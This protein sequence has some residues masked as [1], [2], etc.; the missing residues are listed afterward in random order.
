MNNKKENNKI[1]NIIKINLI[2]GIKVISIVILLFITNSLNIKNMVNAESIN[3]ADV[4][5]IGDC[6]SLLTYQGI[7]VKTNY[8]QYI[9]DGVAYPAYCMDKTKVGVG[10]TPY[11]VSIQSAIQDVGL[12]RRV[13]NGYPYKTIQELGVANKEE[14]FTATKQAIYCYIHGNNPDDYGAIGEAGE[15]TLNAMKKIIN[16]SQNSTE[17]KISSTVTI[18]KNVDE[19]KQDENEKN[20]VSKT[21]TISAGA[22]IENYKIKITRENGQD[23]GGIKLT[24]IDNQEKSEFIPNEK[25]KILIP[26]KNMT[27]NGK[28]NIDVETKVKTKPIL[29]GTA[30]SSE[31]QDYALTGVIYE[32]GIGSA[33]DEYTKNETKIIIIKKD[34]NEGTLLEG[35]E[36]ELLNDNKETAYTG[37]KTNEEGK[38]VVENLVPGVYYLRETKV[39]DGYKI[40]DE[41]IEVKIELNE[42][43]TITV[44]N[45]KEEKLKVEKTKISTKEIKKLPVTGM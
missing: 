14:A 3:A 4:Y 32:D 10:T 6:G 18:N 7:T 5:S 30:P 8:V 20:Y 12:W 24:N 44:D 21:Y 35:V 15:R 41:D 9:K 43:S 37:L 45:I 11:T 22:N 23:I 17:T 38:I 13:I 28:F 27:E 40:S 34:K 26:I 1:K 16:D 39:I 31:Y 19:W 25:F 33:Q 42:E 36:F 29:Y 2:R